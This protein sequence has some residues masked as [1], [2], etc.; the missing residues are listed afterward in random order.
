MGCKRVV[1]PR[2]CPGGLPSLHVSMGLH[3]GPSSQGVRTPLH[4]ACEVGL[5]DEVKRLLAAGADMD[6]EDKVR[7]A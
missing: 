7:W 3:G 6:A 4:V 5:L 1:D 2:V